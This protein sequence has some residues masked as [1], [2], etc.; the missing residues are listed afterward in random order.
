VWADDAV[1][2]DIQGDH[3]RAAQVPFRLRL[4]ADAATFFG[5]DAEDRMTSAPTPSRSPLV[6]LLI[7]DREEGSLRP[8]R[9]TRLEP[10]EAFVGLLPHAYYFA[11]S[12]PARK[13]LMLDRYLRL[14]SSVPTFEVR[15]RPGLGDIAAVL[16]EVEARVL[17]GPS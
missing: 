17:R 8:V 4:H 11:L 6:A 12:D 5:G 14:A 1:V 15:Y 10:T 13:A 9:I 7:L 2:L 3:T 16:D